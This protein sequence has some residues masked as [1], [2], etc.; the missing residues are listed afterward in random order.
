MPHPSPMPTL[1]RR[2]LI[3]AALVLVAELLLIGTLFKH[4]IA[5]E[6]RANWPKAACGGA[7]SA[8][9]GVYGALTGLVLLAWLRPGPFRRLLAGAGQGRPG[10]GLAINLA[11]LGLAM[12]PALW[13]RDGG[14]AGL[15]A[16]TFG[17]WIAGMA[18]LLAGGLIWLAPAARWRGF[19]AETGGAVLLVA[20]AGLVAVWLEQALRPI[21][22]LD[23]VADVT[24]AAVA[25]LT[26]ALGYRV[27]AD[28]AAKVIGAGDFHISVAPVCSGI[29]GIALVTVFVTLYLWLFRAE[30]RFPRALILYPLGIATSA[31]LNVLRIT[32]LLILGIEGHPALAVGGFHSHA[33]WIMFT[34]VALGIVGLARLVPW[35]HRAPAPAGPAA[36][37]PL[38]PLRADPAAARILPFAAFMLTAVFIP[39]VTTQPGVLYPLRVAVVAAVLALF[40]PL[41]GR[42]LR[43]APVAPRALA[44]GAAVGIGWVAIPVAPAA[45]PPY[46]DLA[47]AALLGWLALRAFGTVALVPLIEELFFRD[48]L[49]GRIR[50]VAPSALRAVVAAVV[51][52]ALF[53]ALHDR[54]AEAFVAGLAFSWVMARSGRVTDAIVAHATANLVVML[55]ALVSGNLAII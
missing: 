30:L 18:L 29:E 34:L 3:G 26:A 48:Y 31:V 11:G 13:L 9:I 33:G 24:F 42:L 47:G 38:P 7:S 17:L 43:G 22:Q 20:P 37:A 15:V 8:L 6:C 27:D 23:G 44:V 1:D 10:P 4:G 36:P 50:G 54:W 41:I 40:W 53:A 49:E 35:L 39:A 5:F 21:W 25:R 52:A 46:G 28:P 2:L 12:V 19:A 32:L 45:A 14:G 51:T 16:P 55:A